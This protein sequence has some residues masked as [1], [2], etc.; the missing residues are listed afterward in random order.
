MPLGVTVTVGVM[1][2]LFTP[3]WWSVIQ[4]RNPIDRYVGDPVYPP[5]RPTAVTVNSSQGSMASGTIWPEEERRTHEA[6]VVGARRARKARVR[7]EQRSRWWADV[8]D[9]R[10]ERR[11]AK[12]ARRIMMA[13]RQAAI[14]AFTQEEV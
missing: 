14:A 10:A 13:R 2:R 5:S 9:A 1:V 11:A 12:E 8:M 3:R 7:E 6:R 4:P